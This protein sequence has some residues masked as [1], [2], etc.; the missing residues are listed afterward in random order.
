MMQV[1][2]TTLQD[3]VGDVREVYFFLMGGDLG[4]QNPYDSFNEGASQKL[5]AAY[6]M[7]KSCH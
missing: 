6:P 7:N 2:I 3:S 5:P 4:R 1:A